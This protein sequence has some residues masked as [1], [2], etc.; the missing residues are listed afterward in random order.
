MD[1]ITNLQSQLTDST[2]QG[3]LHKSKLDLAQMRVAELQTELQSQQQQHWVS[4]GLHLST[5]VRTF[6]LNISPIPPHGGERWR[7]TA[8]ESLC[9]ECVFTVLH[10]GTYA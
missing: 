4:I 1:G 2:Q 8:G 6:W 9:V 5:H 7:S 3:T 10:G